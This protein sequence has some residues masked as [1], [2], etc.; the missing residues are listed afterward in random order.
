MVDFKF[1]EEQLALQKKA[2]EF[3]LKEILPVTHYF[4]KMNMMPIFLIK[5]AHEMGL[6][7]LSIG[8]KYGGPGYGLIENALVVEE[9]AAAD[10]GMSTSIFGNT[11]GEEPILLSDNEYVKEKY[12]PILVKEPKI[13]SFATSEP[14]MGSDVAGMRCLAKKDGNDYILNGIKYWITNASYADYCTVFATTDPKSRHKGIVAFLVEMD[15]EG[16][17][18]GEHIPKMGLRTSNTT[19]IKFENVRVPAENVLAGLGEGFKLAMKTFSLTRPIISAFATGAARSALDYSIHYINKRRAFGQ[20]LSDFQN[21]QMKLAEMYQKV[22]TMRLLTLK[23]CWQ[24][25]NKMDPTI[26]ASLAKFYSTEMA[27]EV[28]NQALQMFAGYGYTEFYPIEKI[29]RDIRVL[30]IYEGTSEIQRVVVAR[31]ALSQ[32]K[33][34]MPPI[35]DL[36]RLKGDNIEEAARNGLKAKTAWRCRI[37]GYVHYGEEPPDECPYCRFP[38]SVFKKI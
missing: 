15:Q 19:S 21:T 7:N 36:K 6:Q 17:S 25:D 23:A 3:A 35:E 24:A 18:T 22:E 12:L 33:P 30:T 32:Y 14:T 10:L 37:C 11:L 4:D 13:I 16:V 2:R 29:L 8:K 9:I 31:H 1:T 26:S 27:M 5:K 28:V 38:K 34:I 20:K